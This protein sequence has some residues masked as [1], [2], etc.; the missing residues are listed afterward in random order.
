MKISTTYAAVPPGE[1]IKEQLEIRNMSQK[2]FALRMGFTEKHISKLLNGDTS[3]TPNTA[4]KLESVLG[5]P[6]SYWSRLEASYREKLLKVEEEN[7]LEE[8]LK[9]AKQFPYQTMQKLTWVPKVISSKTEIPKEKLFNL[10]KFFEVS[11]LKLLQKHELS[12]YACRRLVITDKS[13][14]SLMVFAQKVKLESRKYKANTIKISSIEKSIKDIRELT[15]LTPEIFIN[16]LKQILYNCGIIFILLPHI[17]ESH[18]N[19]ISF[20]DG[21]KV[22]IGVSDIGKYADIFWFSIFH[23][24]AHIIFNDIYKQDGTTQEDEIRADNWAKD[25]LIPIDDF[26]RF[27]H[28]NKFE[29]KNILEFS[30]DIKIHPGI[31]LGRLQKE[32]FVEQNRFNYLKQ[33]F[34]IN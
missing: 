17:Q 1:T 26:N 27:I 5:V 10:R 8:E 7:S 30:N 21:K 24:M 28:E 9:I 2:E 31:V 13:D 33:R 29:E 32:C 11:S 34:I 12:R 25:N 6:A 19:G 18:L 3:L 22:I 16:K 4:I 15:L 23:E 20:I 14:I